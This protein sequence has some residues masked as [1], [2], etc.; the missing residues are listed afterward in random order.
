MSDESA[1]ELMVPKHDYD[2]IVEQLADFK[3][4]A[5]RI[6]DENKQL[7]EALNKIQGGIH[8][9][10]DMAEGL[11]HINDQKVIT[12]LAFTLLK[13]HPKQLTIKYK[14]ETVTEIFEEKQ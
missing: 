9:A 10:S 7:K 2:E 8:K 12:D 4:T 1:N 14:G 13:H 11:A 6:I 3:D 5:D